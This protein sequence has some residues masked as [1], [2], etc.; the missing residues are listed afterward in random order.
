MAQPALLA[1]EDSELP[2]VLRED[3]EN[4]ADRFR[5]FD[6]DV[7]R[8]EL[9]DG[10]HVYSQYKKET[11]FEPPHRSPYLISLLSDQQV[12]TFDLKVRVKS[13]HADY[14]HRDVCLV[15]GYQD[16]A[17]FYYVH[18]GKEMD[19]HANQIFVVD[20]APRIKISQT[21]TN[22]TPW[23]DAWHTV[24]IHRDSESG[25]IAVYFD[26]LEQPVMTANDKRFTW[27]QIG[28]GSF[29][30]TSQWDDLD[31]YGQAK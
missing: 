30:D 8:L 25:A 6:D 27:G 7:W 17:H 13:T 9:Q 26:D 12:E 16:P 3:F 15:F 18:L 29:D 14:G 11:S 22:G 21:T 2:L 31:L 28:L 10:G 5:P 19:D 20:D 24:R 4:G 23:D 1:A